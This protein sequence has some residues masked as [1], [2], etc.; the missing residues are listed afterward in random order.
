MEPASARAMYRRQMRNGE[1]LTLKRISPAVE[2]T[3]RG[4]AMG[5]APHELTEGILQGDSRVIVMAEDVTGFTP[6]LRKGDKVVLSDGRQRN[7]EAVDSMTRRVAG[8]LIAYELQ[9]RG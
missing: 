7:I 5:Y 8:E 1:T 2:C 3:V 4:R 6:P 9:V